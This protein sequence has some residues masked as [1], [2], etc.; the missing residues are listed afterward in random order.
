MVVP[1]KTRLHNRLLIVIMIYIYTLL[2]SI[3]QFP[4]LILLWTRYHALADTSLSES[5]MPTDRSVL[6]VRI[7]L[8]AIKIQVF[9]GQLHDALARSAQRKWE[10]ARSEDYV[11]G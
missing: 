2:Y 4:R 8:L 10:M 5:M 9:W 1:L 3:R 11:A 6:N 7:Q